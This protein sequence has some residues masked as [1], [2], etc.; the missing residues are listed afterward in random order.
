MKVK[1][2]NGP[3]KDRIF[4]LTDETVKVKKK[5]VI[6]SSLKGYVEY[7]VYKIRQDKNGKWIGEINV[8]G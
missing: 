5:F 7:C 6:Q 2:I 4:N 8:R 1:F 3:A